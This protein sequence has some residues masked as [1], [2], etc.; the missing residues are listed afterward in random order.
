LCALQT[1]NFVRAHWL[2]RHVTYPGGHIPLE[3][4]DTRDNRV[5]ESIR[6]GNANRLSE[7]DAPNGSSPYAAGKGRA[8]VTA[9]SPWPLT[10]HH[11]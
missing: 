9:D 2:W 11:R 5:S 3:D 7:D 6:A 1:A 8:T 10:H 4:M